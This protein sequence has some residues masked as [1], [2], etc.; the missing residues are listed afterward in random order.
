MTEN[1]DINKIEEKANQLAQVYLE[2][3]H[4]MNMIEDCEELNDMYFDN[5]LLE[6]VPET[7]IQLRK[8]VE[9]WNAEAA[10]AYTH[11]NK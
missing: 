9:A 6:V 3:C 4:L 1:Y 11:R 5:E 8:K 2:M 7:L 10:I